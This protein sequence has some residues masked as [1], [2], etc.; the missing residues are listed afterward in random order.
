M[1]ESDQLEAL[2]VLGNCSQY[3]LHMTVGGSWSSLD[4]MWKMITPVHCE[5]QTAIIQVAASY[6]TEFHSLRRDGI[7]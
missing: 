1:E 2:A 3:S 4:V 6:F 5:N 7:I